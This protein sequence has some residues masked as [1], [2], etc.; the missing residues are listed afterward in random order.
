MRFDCIF[1]G[2][3]TVDALASVDSPLKE[4]EKILADAIF[5][6][7][8]G[9]TATASCAFS[10]AGGRAALLTAIGRDNW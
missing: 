3:N 9:P 4:D 2:L 10:K 8:G 5:L 1:I 6:D 7:G